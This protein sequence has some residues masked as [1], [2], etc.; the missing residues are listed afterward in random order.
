M[1]G[2][3]AATVVKVMASSDLA[4]QEATRLNQVNAEKKCVYKVQ[5]TRFVEAPST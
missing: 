1:N 4:E 3:N 5:T 2:E